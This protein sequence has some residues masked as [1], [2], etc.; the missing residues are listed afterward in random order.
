MNV[1]DFRSWSFFSVYGE[2]EV[3]SKE[4]GVRIRE[5]LGHGEWQM[6]NG[7]TEF[8]QQFVI[9]VDVQR[10]SHFGARLDKRCIQ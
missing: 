9:N 5:F 3:G 7:T 8:I 1:L 10:D 2:C 6:A 4:H